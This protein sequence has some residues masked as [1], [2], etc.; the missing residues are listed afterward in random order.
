MKFSVQ[1]RVLGNFFL[2]SDCAASTLDP[3][4]PPST[5][6]EGRN[7]KRRIFLKKELHAIQSRDAEKNSILGKKQFLKIGTKILKSILSLLSRFEKR[8]CTGSHCV[9]TFLLCCHFGVKF[10]IS[11]LRA[12]PMETWRSGWDLNADFGWFL[13][14][15]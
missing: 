11:A 5:G 6:E 12:G 15:K 8:V 7:G 3:G 13:T 14:L 10:L 1:L 2:Y 4:F 9:K